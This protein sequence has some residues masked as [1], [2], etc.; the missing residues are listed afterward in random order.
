MKKISK[1]FKTCALLAL[2]IL[3]NSTTFAQITDVGLF[4]SGGANDASK[5]LGAYV[6]P[7]TNAFGYNLNAGWYNTAKVHSLLGFDFTLTFNVAF[8]PSADKTFD[9]NDLHLNSNP[10]IITPSIA[11][12]IAGG[13]NPGPLISYT[14]ASNHPIVSYN[15]PGGIN[16][17][18]VPIPMIQ[19]GLGLIKG[20]EIIGRYMPS[21]SLG[22][23]G[24]SKIGLWGIGLKH[25]IKQWIPAIDELPFLNIS[26]I[27]GYS[28]LHMVNEI[29][30]SPFSDFYSNNN[31]LFINGS[32]S[33]DYSNQQLDL[34]VKSFT[35]SAIVSLDI[36]VITFYGGIGFSSTS[37]DLKLLGNF[38]IP[39]TF[40]STQNQVDVTV[41]DIKA[42]P[43][44]ISIKGGT[45]PRL[46][47]GFKL[48]MGLIG[49]NVD[50]TYANY[51][52]TTVGLGVSFR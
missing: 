2:I 38:P 42:N 39:T 15:T 11:Q 46:N 32:D 29:N 28:R 35:A 6:K 12:T 37:T 27:A 47:I 52:I 51:S 14:D 36:P 1:K 40:N 24:K 13:T 21:I 7:F 41:N 3:S 43:V 17:G 26:I 25:S 45:K 20:T 31:I 8:I 49:F 23:G 18:F 50:Y 44:N 22:N 4:V 16:L 9:V 48:K 34:M 33:L 30:L 10:S 19:L 5:L